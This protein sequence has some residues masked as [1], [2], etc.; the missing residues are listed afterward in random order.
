M[1]N[2][3]I[4]EIIIIICVYLSA[5]I[6]WAVMIGKIRLKDDIRNYG[7]KNPGTVNVFRAG[8]ILWGFISAILE[9]SKSAL[10]IFFAIQLFNISEIIMLAC[11]ISALIGHGYSPMRNFK[12]G[13]S[14][15]VTA[16]SWLAITGGEAFYIIAP[17]LLIMKIIQK[18]DALTSTIGFSSLFFYILIRNPTTF[19]TESLLIG[20]LL[21]L[22]FIIFKHRNDYTLKIN[23]RNFA[24]ND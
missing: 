21:N 24:R 11:V 23:F 22:I 6:P 13:K 7:D 4:S 14:L 9:I 15:A 5:S 1:P 2:I 20:I 18:N 17:S 3:S 10:P 12:G 16:G 8:S 19:R